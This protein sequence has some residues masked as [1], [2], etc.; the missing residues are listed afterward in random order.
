MQDFR[1]E[2]LRDDEW[3]FSGQ[4]FTNSLWVDRDGKVQTSDVPGDKQDDLHGVGFYHKDSQ[5]SFVALFLDHSAEG[6][7]EL[8]HTG[9]PTMYYKWHGHVWSRYPLPVKDVPAGAV[10]RQKNAYISVPFTIEDGPAKI[11]RMRRCMMAP[12][13]PSG[14]DPLQIDGIAEGLKGTVNSTARLARPGESIDSLEKKK[15]IWDALHDC[16]DGQLYKADISVV[17]LGL[18]YDVRIRG[19]VVTVLMTMPHQGRTRLGYFVDGSTSVHPTLSVPIR[20]RL[21]QIPGVRHVVVE[22]TWEPAWTSNRLTDSGRE[23]L[24]LPLSSPVQ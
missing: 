11:E 15:Q 1:A 23:K 19:D 6:I 9:S 5:D 8:K 21:M 10:L 18:V 22:Q 24:G 12:L 14:G 17:E 2:A 4:S 13:V 7:P 16:K 3:V 20:E